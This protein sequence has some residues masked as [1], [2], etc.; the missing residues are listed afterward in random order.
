MSH[1]SHIFELIV[2]IFAHTKHTVTNSVTFGP[3]VILGHSFYSASTAY[4]VRLCKEPVL[5]ARQ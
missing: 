5:V 4:R 1:V 3:L 2:K